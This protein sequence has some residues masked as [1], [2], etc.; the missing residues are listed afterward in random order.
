MPNKKLSCT[1]E[2]DHAL[3]AELEFIALARRNKLI[4]Y[5]LADLMGL[6]EDGADAYAV[7]V[8]VADLEEPG[9]EDV[10]RKVMADIK[11]KGLS[12]SETQLRDKM[13]HLLCVARGQVEDED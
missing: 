1:H 5:W 7:E 3:R 11:A 4:G 12:V 9:D 8:A 6:D 10:V 13:E 2:I